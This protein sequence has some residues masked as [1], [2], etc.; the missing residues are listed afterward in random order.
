M[1]RFGSGALVVLAVLPFLYVLAP[2]TALVAGTSVQSITSALR[3]AELRDAFLTSATSALT[4]LAIVCVIGLPCAFLLA[5]WS[6]AG[7]RVAEILLLLPLVLPPLVGG[8]AELTL[9]GPNTSL[10]RAAAG[11]G[12]SLTDSW[13]GVVLAQ[14]FVTA[15]FLV[16]AAKAGFED[17]PR[18][19]PEAA[20]LSGAGPWIQL[21]YL[22][23]PLAIKPILVGMMLTF[24]RAF[25][26]FGATMMMAYHPYTV[27][28]ELYVQFSS[29]GLPFLLP[30]ATL[31]ILGAI[32]LALI[33]SLFR[34]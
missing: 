10:G 30:V 28:V 21:I 26:E 29:G 22:Y 14:L 20:S 4:T 25:G 34:R 7:K 12:W 23:I 11:G 16:L 32:A 5:R 17:V 6:G 31:V 19:L 1:K 33:A 2:L 9:L 27:P 15:P 18:E 8:M 13:S 3:Q 24:T